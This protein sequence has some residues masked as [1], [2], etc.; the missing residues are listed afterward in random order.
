MSAA[1]VYPRSMSPT[2]RLLGRALGVTRHVA[3][4]GTNKVSAK[5]LIRWGFRG[6]VPH[7]WKAELVT[8]DATAMTLAANKPRALKAMQDAG[9]PVPPF[10]T[11]W[12]VASQWLKDGHVVLGR[13]PTGFGGK[14]IRVFK[15]G[16]I[17]AR[18]SWYSQ[19]VQNTR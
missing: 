1:I 11:S 18:C 5:K 13:N 17:L 9:L 3:E 15:P 16:S 4:R 10:T 2:G 12:D 7:E 6:V 8:N 14:D 19:H